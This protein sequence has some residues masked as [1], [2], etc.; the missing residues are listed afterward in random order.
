VRTRQREVSA[1]R[2]FTLIEVLAAIV[3]IAIVLPIA[4]NG[5]SLALFAAENAKQQAEAAQLAEK[6]L[7]EVTAS[8]T[9]MAGTLAGDFGD[10]LPAYKWQSIA[11]SRDMGILEVTMQVTWNSRGQDRNVELTTWVYQQQTTQ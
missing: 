3:F 5:I 8:S 7:A 4:M 9:L 6:Q 10:T 1:R 2:G 11:V